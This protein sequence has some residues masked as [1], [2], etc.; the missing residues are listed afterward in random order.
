MAGSDTGK[1]MPKL[2]AALT[3][4]ATVTVLVTVSAS[5]HAQNYYPF[6]GASY[7]EALDLAARGV[8]PGGYWIGAGGNI[9]SSE[10][11]Y[12]VRTLNDSNLMSDGSCSF[13]EGVTV[14]NC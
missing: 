11:G 7:P 3:A 8:P 4:A 5:T 10:P 1:E 14:G 2:S 13:V 12:N 9:A 6:N